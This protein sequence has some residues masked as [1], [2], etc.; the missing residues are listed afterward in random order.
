MASPWLAMLV[1]AAWARCRVC[2][3][4]ARACSAS[5]CARSVDIDTHLVGGGDRARAGAR[6]R[7]AG[8][9]AARHGEPADD[10]E[11]VLLHGAVH[12]DH[13]LMAALLGL[14]DQGAGLGELAV[15]LGQEL[16]RGDEYRAA[17]AGVGV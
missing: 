14:F 10:R 15:M 9:A 13:A 4:R 5:R 1:S 6:R 3:C 12:L 11:Q 8:G 17:Q 16:G 2:S 7:A